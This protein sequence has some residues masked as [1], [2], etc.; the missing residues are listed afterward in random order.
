MYRMSTSKKG[1]VASNI[2]CVQEI[3]N[4]HG[5]FI[6]SIVR[7]N[8]SNEA[9]SE[10]LFQDLLLFLILKPIPEEVQNVRGFLYR[11]VSDMTKDTYRRINREQQR[12]HKYSKSRKRIIEYRPEN[13]LIEEEETKK[14]FELIEKHLPP[15]EALAVTL[16]Y[17]NSYNA[18]EVADKMSIKQESVRRYISVG[19]KKIRLF[20]KTNKGNEHVHF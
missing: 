3:L 2:N 19:L 18:A 9:L 8:V 16:R 10:D 7:F 4:E 17:K 13:S 15:S 6:R 1:E 20:L 12:I 5:S 14:M 11:L